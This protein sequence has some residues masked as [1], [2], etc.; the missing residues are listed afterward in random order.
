MLPLCQEEGVGVITYNPLAGGFL[1]GKHQREAGPEHGSRFTLGASGDLY[2]RRYWQDAQFEA[3]DRFK[4]F[5]EKRGKPLV[6]VAVAWVLAQPAI[7]S[8]I[9]GAT[10]PEQLAGSLPAT[11]MQLDAEEMAF[12]DSLWY[13]LPRTPEPG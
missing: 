1:T 4:A 8:A 9:I 12:L 5:F 7:T 6:Q 10:K 11:D 3:V 13:D 2:R